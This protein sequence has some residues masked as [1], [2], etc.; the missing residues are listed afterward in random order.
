MALLLVV[1]AAVVQDG[2][3]LVV[4]KKAAPDVLYLPGGK[5]EPGE[6]PRQTLIRELDE[7]LG[8]LPAE[9]TLLADVDELSSLERVPMRM[10]VFTAR[11][12]QVP[13]PAAELAALAW[14]T[15][16]DAYEPLLAPAL[17]RHVIPVLRAAGLLGRQSAP[18]V[19]FPENVSGLG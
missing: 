5:P 14:T 3:L 11:L 13:R 9:V 8:V 19:S 18:G 1:A 12:V 7:E 15:G 6:S 17:T 4:S 2:R 10:T 16:T